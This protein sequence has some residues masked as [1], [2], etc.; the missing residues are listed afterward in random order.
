MF[1]GLESA[2]QSPSC[3][4]LDGGGIGALYHQ[5]GMGG[6]GQ[7]GFF[8]AGMMMVGSGREVV[9]YQRMVEGAGNVGIYGPDSLQ[10]VYSS[11]DM[12]QVIAQKIKHFLLL[13]HLLLLFF[14][15]FA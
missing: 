11:G 2:V 5:A 14:I 3:A 13:L 12:Q 10:R 4:F 8:S 6:E 15:F 9:E 1:V 7:P